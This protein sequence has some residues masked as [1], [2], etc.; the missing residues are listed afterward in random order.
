M[1]VPTTNSEPQGSRIRSYPCW[2]AAQVLELLQTHRHP[3][4]GI[5][6]TTVRAQA[7]RFAEI[8]QSNNIDLLYYF[9]CIVNN[10]Y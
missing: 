2:L 1:A 4:L 6:T 9:D 3:Q 10:R 5:G 8:N 7:F